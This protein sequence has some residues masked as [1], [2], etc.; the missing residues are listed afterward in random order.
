M[1]VLYSGT[2]LIGTYAPLGPYSRIISRAQWWSQ[3][4]SGLWFRTVANR[5][6]AYLEPSPVAA[7]ARR[8]ELLP[9]TCHMANA[10]QSRPDSCLGV[11]VHVLQMFYVIPSSLSSGVDLEP[12]PVAAGARREDLLPLGC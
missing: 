9:L 6:R 4:G 1:N 2:L 8:E 3:G 10:R 11:Q 5:S 7:G 12:A